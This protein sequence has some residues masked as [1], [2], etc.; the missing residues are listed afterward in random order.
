M[1]VGISRDGG[2]YLV[3]VIGTNIMMYGCSKLVV[4]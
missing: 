2:R 4:R 1:D 3:E